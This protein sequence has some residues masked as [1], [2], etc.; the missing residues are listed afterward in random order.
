MESNKQRQ[1]QKVNKIK[2]YFSTKT[3]EQIFSLCLLVGIIAL[4]LFCCIVRLCGGLWF[5]ADLS[6]IQEPSK[7][8]QE[9]IKGALL[10]FE[11]IFVYKLL[12]RTKW[13]L[14]LIISVIETGLGILISYLLRNFDYGQTITN[15]FYMLCIFII[16]LPFVRHWFSLIDSA[17]L[18]TMEILYSLIF[19][20]GR[21]GGLNT[22]GYNFVSSVI[23]MVD[24]KLFAVSLFLIINYFGGIRLWK[25]Q[26]R[27][28][29]QKNIYK[30]S[31]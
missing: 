8:W 24:F 4:M 17:V 5:T 23:G 7:A 2:E 29:L 3:S 11:L 31:A 6:K 20:V 10:V 13:W 15:I 1:S 21:I 14:C 30:T 25:N 9:V 19:M 18:Y 28:I 22:S 26:K 16:P 12:C 27:L